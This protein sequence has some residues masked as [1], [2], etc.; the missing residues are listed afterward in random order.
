MVKGKFSKKVSKYENDCSF[1]KQIF[2]LRETNRNVREMYQLNFSIPNY[3]Q[4]CFGKS[5]WKIFGP[6]YLK[7]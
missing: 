2:E 7:F 4:V 6:I 1:I 5:S 3:N